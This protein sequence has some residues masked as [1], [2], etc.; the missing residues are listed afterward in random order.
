VLGSLVALA[1]LVVHR[2]A[3]PWGLLLALVTTFA[4]PWWLLR[5]SAPR[6]AGSYV[7]GWL[8][9]LGLA[10][11]GRPEGDFVVAADAPGYALLVAGLVLVLVGVVSFPRTRARLGGAVR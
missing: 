9:L 1:A 10:V 6:T 7:V 11:T 4:V 5:S 3:L 2:S 8:A